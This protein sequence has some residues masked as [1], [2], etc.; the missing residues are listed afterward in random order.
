M[1]VNNIRTSWGVHTS[2][3]GRFH[4]DLRFDF[5]HYGLVPR[6]SPRQTDLFPTLSKIHLLGG[7]CLSWQKPDVTM[8]ERSVAVG[9]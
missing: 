1:I 5:D 2:R 9:V 6:S 3:M 4:E 7:A 8:E